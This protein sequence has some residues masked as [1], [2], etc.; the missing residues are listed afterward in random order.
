MKKKILIICGVILAVI[1]IMYIPIPVGKDISVAIDRYSKPAPKF[2]GGGYIPTG[3][4]APERYTITKN[5]FVYMGNSD[6]KLVKILNLY[7][8][9][10]LANQGEAYA[11]K[12]LD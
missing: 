3:T 10:K 2:D 1:I 8:K 9:I 6:K 7:Q 4:M 12:I 5:G 11:Y